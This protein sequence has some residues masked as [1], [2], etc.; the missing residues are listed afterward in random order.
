MTTRRQFRDE[1]D[2]PPEVVGL[3]SVIHKQETEISALKTTVAK[4]EAF[5]AEAAAAIR[6]LPRPRAIVPP[7][8]EALHA[9]VDALLVLADWHAGEVVR[10]EET[11]GYGEYCW[12]TMLAR[13]WA[14]AQKTGELVTIMRQTSRCDRLTVLVLGD[15][16][17]GNI[18]EELDRTNEFALPETVVR[19]GRV[20][21]EVVTMLA[22]RF[23]RIDVLAVPGNHGRQD[24]KP[25]AKQFAARNWDTAVYQIARAMSPT[26]I[27]WAIPESRA[28]RVDLDGCR[29][30]AKH[31][32]D[33]QMQGGVVPF[34]GL[35]RD[36]AKEHAKRAGVDDFDLIVQGHLHDHYV[37]PGRVVAP[38]LVGTNEYAFERLHAVSQPAQLLAFSC[39]KRPGR[40]ICQWP[41]LLDGASGNGFCV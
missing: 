29:L 22:A 32:D 3:R 41:I 12:E 36:T 15:I 10:A 17:S 27:A 37:L 6:R 21:A 16:V 39:A 5:D 20:L 13:A 31:G 23:E 11:E 26:S 18:H 9:P 30:L 33:V 19:T 14:T 4:L 40:L 35:A 28:V 7:E 24:R 34:Y 38:A 2:P 8:V 25:V 1:A